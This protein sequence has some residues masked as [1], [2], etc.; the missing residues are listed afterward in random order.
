MMNFGFDTHG[1]LEPSTST[2]FQFFYSTDHM[3]NHSYN[4]YIYHDDR[5]LLL[6]ATNRHYF[7]KQ[8]AVTDKLFIVRWR[9]GAS[10]QHRVRSSVTFGVKDRQHEA[11]HLDVTSSQ[12]PRIIF[13]ADNISSFWR[14]KDLRPLLPTGAGRT[15]LQICC[16]C[17]DKGQ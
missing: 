4:T 8:L 12:L 16:R 7:K 9:A 11:A 15:S 1:K 14:G 13:P 5:L 10:C 6:I 17:S 2:T 3:K